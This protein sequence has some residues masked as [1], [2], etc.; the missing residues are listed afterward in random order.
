M[1]HIIRVGLAWAGLSAL[2]AACSSS[3][4]SKASGSDAGTGNDACSPPPGNPGDGSSAC[5]QATCAPGQY[6]FD[7]AVGDCENGCTAT[8]N[9]ATG[10]YCDLTN[11][12]TDGMQRAIG[13]CRMPP[14]CTHAQP[15]GGACPDV[16]GVYTVTLDTAGSSSAC[17]NGIPASTSCTVVQSSCSLTWSC[18]PGNGFMTSSIDASGTSPISVPAPGGGTATCTLVF[19]NDG[20]TWDCQFA[21]MGTAV[22]CKGTGTRM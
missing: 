13:T 9:C 1:R 2:A 19:A 17:A 11:P 6:C 14:S 16:H 21:G 5:G 20:F 18:N 10:E 22:D 15:E 3:S 7:N 8:D 12:T 4:S